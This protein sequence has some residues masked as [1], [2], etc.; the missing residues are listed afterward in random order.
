L[1]V[2]GNYNGAVMKIF[3][4][5][6]CLMIGN[7]QAD[8]SACHRSHRTAD[9]CITESYGQRTADQQDP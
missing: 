5:L 6:F 4:V 1:G 2:D 9:H 8:Q 3:F 7:P